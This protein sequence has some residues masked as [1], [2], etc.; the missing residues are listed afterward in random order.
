MIDFDDMKSILFKRDQLVKYL[1]N[2]FFDNI[3]RNALVLHRETVGT[4]LIPI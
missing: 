3:V 2:P 1:Q 4:V